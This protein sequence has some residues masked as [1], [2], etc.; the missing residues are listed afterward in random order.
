[1]RIIAIVVLS[2]VFCNH[3]L[4]AAQPASQYPEKDSAKVSKHKLSKQE[5][6]LRQAREE[7]EGGKL[8][9]AL[10]HLEKYAKKMDSTTAEVEYLKTKCYYSLQKYGD[11]KEHLNAFL[12]IGKDTTNADYLE[13][14]ALAVQLKLKNDETFGE[15][16]TAGLVGGGF[17]EQ[18][19]W[20]YA[21][22]TGNVKIYR[23][24]L[25]FFPNGMHVEE[26]KK[27]V[28]Y[29][30]KKESTP[31]KLLVDAVRRADWTLIKELI[32]KGADVNYVEVH[33]NALDKAEG[34][35]SEYFFETPL[36]A[37]LVKLDYTLSKYL[38]EQ[39]ADPNRFMYRKVYEADKRTGRTRTI[40]ENLII[41]TSK[42]GIYSGQDAKLIDLMDLMMHYGLD[43]DYY[44]GSPIS[45]AV[46]YHDPKKYKR[47]LLIRYMLR[48]GADPYLHGIDRSA[49]QI[50]RERGD[51]AMLTILRDKK[52]K[53]ARKRYQENRQKGITPPMPKATNPAPSPKPAGK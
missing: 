34:K 35:V 44:Q 7:V 26:A 12:A 14:K 9:E 40:L 21:Q 6:L 16:D 47:T 13:M 22:R 4:L 39:G 28:D 36:S 17:D 51:K 29:Y 41:A 25:R 31:S 33:K 50:A 2:L 48:K 46:F 19:T 37:A 53:D 38:L 30:D 11:A 24:Y 23:N 52:Y 49:V 1:M 42:N 32:E 43:L 5:K 15:R 18:K 20:E 10:Q 3:S 27:V 8:D 45:T